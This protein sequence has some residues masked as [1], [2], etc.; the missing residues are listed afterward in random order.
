[1][2]AGL[3]LSLGTGQLVLFTFGVF[4][5]P[6]VTDT[7]WDQAIVGSG[8]LCGQVL[9]ALCAPFAG[10]A[11]DRFGPRAVARF[12]GP[13]LATVMCLIGHLATSQFTF[14]MAVSLS[15]LL[16]AFQVPVTYVKA[17]AARYRRGLGLA[18]GTAML[19]SGISVAVV[20][21]LA[22]WLISAV[23]WRVAY[24][25]LGILVAVVNLF[26]VALLIREPRSSD[27]ESRWA[28]PSSHST[29]FSYWPLLRS[30]GF[31]ATA[32]S[33][34]LISVVVGAGAWALPVI[35]ND[36]GMSAQRSSFVMVV[37][38]V[39]M[40]FARLG[41]GV[42]LDKLE[43]R[44]LTALAFVGAVGMVMLATTSLIGVVTA[45]VLTGIALGSEVDAMA[46]LSTRVFGAANLGAMY[47]ALSFC[48][49]LGL[50][51]GPV[52]LGG[53]ESQRELR[54]RLLGRRRGR[55]NRSTGDPSGAASIR[56]GESTVRIFVSA[57]GR[58][59]LRGRNH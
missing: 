14:L 57:S 48:F 22:A 46:F 38:G 37:V 50:G 13:L 17:I 20:P 49:S 55:R 51:C 12:A 15:F 24:C 3:N 6:I 52:A 58:T 19:F 11:I 41:F 42:L 1:V 16:G 26:S 23:G 7:G 34:F 45:G 32:A 5:K 30:G 9:L 29:P 4:V 39:S 2:G 31:R 44:H 56:S 59:Q 35:L 47:G 43:P 8:T 18:L 53:H 33:F 36:L 25:R 40:T 28:M 21:P 54:C 27:A 10:L